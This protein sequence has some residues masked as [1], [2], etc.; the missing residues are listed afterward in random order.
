[1][2]EVRGGGVGPARDAEV[3]HGL[4]GRSIV[5]MALVDTIG[6]GDAMRQLEGEVAIKARKARTSLVWLE[7][8]LLLA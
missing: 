7:I 1:M 3:F 6:I 8:R 2:V 5:V 4:V